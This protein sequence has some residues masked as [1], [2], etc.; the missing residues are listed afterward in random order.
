[1]STDVIVI[2]I[3]AFKYFDSGCCLVE[4]CKESSMTTSNIDQEDDHGAVPKSL[5]LSHERTL[6]T[7][8]SKSTLRQHEKQINNEA[9]F[10]LAQNIH[11]VSF[12]NYANINVHY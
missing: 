3:M 12:C 2:V 9:V 1:M 6:I 10:T 5:E 8:M 4:Q 11:T 7:T